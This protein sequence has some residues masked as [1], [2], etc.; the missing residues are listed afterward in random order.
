MFLAVG[1][2]G[3][4]TLVFALSKN[5]YL[6]LAALAV[7]GAADMVSVYVRQTLVQIVTP[8]HMRRRVSSVSG[9]FISRSNELGEVESGIAAVSDTQLDVYKSQ[10]PPCPLYSG[11]PRREPGRALRRR[12]SFSLSFTCYCG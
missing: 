6:S 12:A 8:D 11:D 10:P 5:M 1:A 2:F 3:F 9:L 4:A 7:L